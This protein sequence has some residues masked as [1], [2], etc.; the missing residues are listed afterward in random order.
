MTPIQ[1]G[2]LF[3]CLYLGDILATYFYMR[4]FRK[5]YPKMDYKELEINGVVGYLWNRFGFETGTLLAP[6]FLSPFW[7]VGILGS[8]IMDKI[9]YIVIG[10]YILLYMIHF[11]N[12]VYILVKKETNLDRMYN[13][14]YGKE[15]KSGIAYEICKG[16]E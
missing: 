10:I 4:I 1:I 13:K 2:I 16:G 7:F 3:G 5:K 15:Q 11:S 8:M 6:I 9:I 12:F 14:V